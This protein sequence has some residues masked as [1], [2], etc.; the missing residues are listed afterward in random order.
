MLGAGDEHKKKINF[1]VYGKQKGIMLKYLCMFA[2]KYM[3]LFMNTGE[4]KIDK[5]EHMF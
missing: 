5:I 4:T 3:S 2:H 1:F